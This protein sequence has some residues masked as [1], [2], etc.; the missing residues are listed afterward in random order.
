MGIIPPPPPKQLP[1]QPRELLP[2]ARRDRPIEPPLSRWRL[3][4]FAWAVADITAALWFLLEKPGG[5]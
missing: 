1:E 3:W 5:H 2:N 4:A